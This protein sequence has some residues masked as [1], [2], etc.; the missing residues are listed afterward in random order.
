MS[1]EDALEDE[2]R[3]EEMRRYWDDAAAVFDDEPDHGLHEPEVLHAW[4]TLLGT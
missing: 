3:L 4:T 2:R 1:H